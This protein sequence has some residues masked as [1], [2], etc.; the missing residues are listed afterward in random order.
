M[1]IYYFFNRSIFDQNVYK[2]YVHLAPI[3]SIIVNPKIQDT[4]SYSILYGLQ[5]TSINLALFFWLCS[6][7]TFRRWF[8]RIRRGWKGRIAYR[9]METTR[10]A[11]TDQRRSMPFSWW[12]HSRD[13][14]LS[15]TPHRLVGCRCREVGSIDIISG[16]CTTHAE[17]TMRFRV[18]AATYLP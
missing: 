1:Y 9:H 18:C 15:R 10:T 4:A 5:A 17:F 13:A 8:R 6:S 2:L 3:I 7:G 16:L 12:M 14:L 11:P